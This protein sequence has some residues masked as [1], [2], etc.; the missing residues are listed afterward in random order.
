VVAAI[1]GVIGMDAKAA[2]WWRYWAP[3]ELRRTRAILVTTHLSVGV[4][5]ALAGQTLGW[6]PFSGDWRLANSIVYAAA[7]E[8]LFRTEVTGFSLN[9]I[10]VGHSPLR[11]VLRH[12]TRR[13][14]EQAIRAV[15]ELLGACTDERLA[16]V[17]YK[18]V[19]ETY[20]RPGSSDGARI[21]SR[22][23]LEDVVKLGKVLH[24]VD[25]TMGDDK[26]ARARSETITLIRNIIVE[27]GARLDGPTAEELRARYALEPGRRSGVHAPVDTA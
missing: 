10:V 24:S 27:N 2:T 11:T 21:G 16:A 20:A 13:A 5:A 26:R 25:V 8:A 7:G 18:V 3:E 4:I 22:E 15:E 6:E 19:E 1:S 9:H 23:L 17:A 12:A 14:T